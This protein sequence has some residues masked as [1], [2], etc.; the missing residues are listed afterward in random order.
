[1]ITG[2]TNLRRTSVLFISSTWQDVQWTTEDYDNLGAFNIGTSDINLTVPTG[3]TLMRAMIR[4]A[5]QSSFTN[6]FFNLRNTAGTMYLG[7]IREDEAESDVCL[8][9]G[10]VAVTAG[11]TIW[12]EVSSIGNLNLG[13]TTFG[14]INMSIEWATAWTDLHT[15]GVT[16]LRKTG[17]QSI[18]TGAWRDVT[19]DTE[20]YDN[21]GAWT[22]GAT[23]TVPS[24]ISLMRPA[25]VASWANNGNDFRYFKLSDGTTNFLGDIR[26]ATSESLCSV[27]PGWV[28][29]SPGATIKLQ[30][31]S[32]TQT[33]NLGGTFN[34]YPELCLEWATGWDAIY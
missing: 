33:L 6:R 15:A 14:L 18:A 34:H 31:N 27:C 5:W 19:W 9:S 20:D 4:T 22:S 32:G 8:C 3:I 28:S 24:G 11:D 17:T 7:D 2:I 25:L 1:M 12:L 13:N 23:I 21:L 29:V 26:W 16:K 30:A 10:W